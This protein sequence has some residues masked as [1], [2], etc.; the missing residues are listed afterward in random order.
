MFC[1]ADTMIASACS[2]SLS[3]NDASSWPLVPET[4]CLTWD[5]GYSGSRVNRLF[6]AILTNIAPLMDKPRVMPLN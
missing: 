2:R 4:T 6:D 1:H 5:F 3:D